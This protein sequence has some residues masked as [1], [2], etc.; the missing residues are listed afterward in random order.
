M[1]PLSFCYLIEYN[2]D[3]VMPIIDDMFT[4]CLMLVEIA[5]LRETDNPNPGKK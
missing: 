5:L 2:F 4:A 1:I 3:V